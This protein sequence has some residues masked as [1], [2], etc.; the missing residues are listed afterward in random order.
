MRG[1]GTEKAPIKTVKQTLILFFFFS[2]DPASLWREESGMRL[3]AVLMAAYLTSGWTPATPVESEKCPAGG[4]SG[5]GDRLENT[6]K[7]LGFSW[8]P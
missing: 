3:S 5:I 1:V 6:T 7:E 4:S 8:C 2:K